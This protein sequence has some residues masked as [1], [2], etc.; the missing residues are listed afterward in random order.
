MVFEG[1]SGV[2]VPKY[3]HTSVSA[4]LSAWRCERRLESWVE[5]ELVEGVV[6]VWEVFVSRTWVH[7]S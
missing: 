5:L 3:L 4:H 2:N 1:V 6:G 7:L